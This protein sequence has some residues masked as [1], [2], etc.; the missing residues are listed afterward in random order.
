MTLKH[1][2]RPPD[3]TRFRAR[4]EAAQR[5]V[6]TAHRCTEE[7]A[8]DEL[9]DVASRHHLDFAHFV[10][11]FTAITDPAVNLTPA[12]DHS[13][14]RA[15][16]HEHRQLLAHCTHQ[17]E[18]RDIAISPPQVR[19]RV[20][21]QRTRRF[22]GSGRTFPARRAGHPTTIGESNS[23]GNRHHPD[24]ACGDRMRR[25]T[26]MSLQV[27][28]TIDHDE[29]RQWI[30]R[31]HGAP[32]RKPDP[33]TASAAE[34]LL[35]DFIGARSGHY[36]EHISWADWFA[37]FDDHRLCFRYPTNP[38]SLLFHLIRREATPPSTKMV[39]LG[40]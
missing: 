26:R 36:F 4:L 27:H 7:Q 3:A 10:D 15:I 28:D 12:D 40:P 31:H 38:D 21:P 19:C 5:V 9:L 8:F 32:A 29:I 6:M 13:S 20:P 22:P 35:V 23:P 11:E 25:H 18:I 34:V 17:T 1:S 30:Q 24:R 37:W 33:A 39:N 16:A 2:T 14:A